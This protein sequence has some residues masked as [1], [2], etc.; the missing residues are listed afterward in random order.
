MHE[1]LMSDPLAKAIMETCMAASMQETTGSTPP[2]IKRIKLKCPSRAASPLPAPP[3][4]PLSLHS[5]AVSSPRFQLACRQRALVCLDIEQQLSELADTFDAVV[6]IR[7]IPMLENHAQAE[8]LAAH[9]K[10]WPM[11]EEAQVCLIRLYERFPPDD[12]EWSAALRV[13]IETQRLQ[14][15]AQIVRKCPSLY[16]STLAELLCGS[17]PILLNALLVGALSSIPEKSMPILIQQLTAK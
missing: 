14:L 5:D 2:T 11:L 9:L 4:S 3:S 1:D 16:E 8:R 15:I 17:N 7:L 10:R 12:S 13:A 6:V